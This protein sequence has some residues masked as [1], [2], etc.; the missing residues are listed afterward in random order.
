MLEWKLNNSIDQ[1]GFEMIGYRASGHVWIKKDQSRDDCWNQRPPDLSASYCFVRQPCAIW[2]SSLFWICLT[3]NRQNTFRKKWFLSDINLE[4][5]ASTYF[6]II[7]CII[8]CSTRGLMFVTCF[9][10]H[11]KVH[12]KRSCSLPHNI[13]SCCVCWTVG[14]NKPI[15]RNTLSLFPKG[16]VPS[17][18]YIIPTTIYLITIISTLLTGSPCKIRDRILRAI[19]DLRE[20]TD[21][22]SRSMC[23]PKSELL[24]LTDRCWLEMSAYNAILHSRS[25]ML[26]VKLICPNM[27]Y[28]LHGYRAKMSDTV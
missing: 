3:C 2:F 23:T 1:M 17:N 16:S 21:K 13:S 14:T 20:P 10:P 25:G 6:V 8:C 28:T 4:C 12:V 11:W 5:S 7:D 27:C 26:L 22:L 9:Y 19:G 24:L 18:T 15:S